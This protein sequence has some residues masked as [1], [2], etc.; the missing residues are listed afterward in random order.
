MTEYDIEILDVRSNATTGH[1][2][3]DVCAVEENDGTV[4]RG[5]KRTYG[6]DAT[7]LKVQYNNNVHEWLNKVKR[8]HQNHHGLHISLLGTLEALKGKRI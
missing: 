2:E 3:V 6:I 7:Q 4:R 1:I 8:E 5:P